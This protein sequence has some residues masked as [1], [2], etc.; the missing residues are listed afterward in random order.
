MFLGIKIKEY[1]SSHKSGL[2]AVG[3]YQPLL[4]IYSEKAFYR[5]MHYRIVKKHGHSRSAS[6][7]IVSAQG[8]PVG[9]HPITVD[10][11]CDRIRK[12]IVD[13]VSPLLGHHILMSLE[14][15]CWSVF[16]PRRGSL[17]HHHIAHLVSPYGY[18]V[19]IGPVHKERLHLVKM[20]RRT[21]HSG[22]LV[23]TLPYEFRLQI[24]HFHSL[25]F[26]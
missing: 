3:A 14:N 2:K 7:T 23:E 22:D 24:F 1:R 13:F 10:K 5:A 9:F 6:Q 21:R 18:I 8:R 25:N 16:M 11:R 17:T 12:E 15:D 4:L 26:K 20:M 19:A